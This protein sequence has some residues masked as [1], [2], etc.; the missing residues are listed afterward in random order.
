LMVATLALAVFL[1]A[2]WFR[3][4]SMN[5]GMQGAPIESPTLFGLDL[6]I[7]SGEGYPR[8]AFGLVC[9]VVLAAVAWCVAGL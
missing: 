9:L 5:G 8:V 1:E 2:F 4:P 6:G 7:G 3:N